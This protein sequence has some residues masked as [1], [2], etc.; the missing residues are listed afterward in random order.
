L[1]E[2]GSHGALFDWAVGDGL[3][4][5]LAIDAP[6]IRPVFNAGDALLFDDLLLHRTGISPGMDTNRYAL[7][8][9]FFSPSHYPAEQLPILF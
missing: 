9:W 1:V 5:E 6:V 7:E 3:A 4:D 2:T 8:H